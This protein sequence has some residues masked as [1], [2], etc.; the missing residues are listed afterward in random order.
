[1]K[2]FSEHTEVKFPK[3][4]Q[5]EIKTRKRKKLFISIDIWFY[6]PGDSADHCIGVY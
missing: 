5:Q 3:V 1:M 6:R 2:I 4:P